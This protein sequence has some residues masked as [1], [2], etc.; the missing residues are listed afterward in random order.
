MMMRLGEIFAMQ[1]YQ[2]VHS[3]FIFTDCVVTLDIIICSVN[4]FYLSYCTFIIL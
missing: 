1:S 4:V 2:N 3:A